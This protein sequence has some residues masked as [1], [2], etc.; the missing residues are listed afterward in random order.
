MIGWLR[1]HNQLAVRP[2]LKT[3]HRKIILLIAACATPRNV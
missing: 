3:G 2:K 1:I